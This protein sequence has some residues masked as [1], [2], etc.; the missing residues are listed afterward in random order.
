MLNNQPKVLQKKKQN[1]KTLWIVLFSDDDSRPKNCILK[2]H[3]LYIHSVYY[4]KSVAIKKLTFHIAT[5]FNTP[6]VKDHFI[7]AAK[8]LNMKSL[9]NIVDYR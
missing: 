2:L 7:F 3:V 8:L 1:K 6:P 9:H 4:N 5:A